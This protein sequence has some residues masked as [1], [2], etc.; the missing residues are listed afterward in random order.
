[1][2]DFDVKLV[3]TE[4]RPP[5]CENGVGNFEDA[6]VDLGVTLREATNEILIEMSACI[7]RRGIIQ[8]E[9]TDVSVSHLLQKSESAI[10]LMASPSW[11]WTLGGHEIIRP[12]RRSLITWTSSSGSL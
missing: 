10:T 5:S 8:H 6:D 3:R 11:V 9:L 7:Q 1:M 2:V 4:E 12:M